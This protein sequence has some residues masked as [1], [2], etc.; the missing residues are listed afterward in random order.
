[1]TVKNCSRRHIFPVY[2]YQ[3]AQFFMKHDDWWYVKLYMF[4]LINERNEHIFIWSFG[5][6]WFH[7]TVS[8]GKLVLIK[9]DCW[10]QLKMEQLILSAWLSVANSRDHQIKSVPCTSHRHTL[11]AKVSTKAFWFSH[12]RL[13]TPKIMSNNFLYEMGTENINTLHWAQLVIL[14]LLMSRIIFKQ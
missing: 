6:R 7:I 4:L 11:S 12:S 2:N 13:N 1:M 10:V 9:S 14:R 3:P 5:K 8:H